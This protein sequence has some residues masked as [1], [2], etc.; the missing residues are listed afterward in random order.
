MGTLAASR[1]NPSTSGKTFG[2][3]HLK[4]KHIRNLLSSHIRALLFH[5]DHLE[6][7]P[8]LVTTP[9]GYP[10]QRAALFVRHSFICDNRL[11]I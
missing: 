11:R 7:C 6:R 9:G 2:S 10:S 3:R 1:M 8:G 5:R 4:N